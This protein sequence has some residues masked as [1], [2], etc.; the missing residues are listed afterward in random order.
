MHGDSIVFSIFLIF[1]GAAIFATIALFLRQA[2]LVA[3]LILGALCGPWGF[4]LVTDPKVIQDIAQIGIIFLLFLL[5]LNLS[6]LKLFQ[7]LKET[8]HIT[9]FCTLVFGGV[10]GAIAWLFDL[11]L[12]DVIVIGICASFS[13]TIIGLKLLPTTVLHHRHIGEVIISVLLFQDLIAIIAMLVMHGITQSAGEVS[14][15]LLDILFLFVALPGVGLTAWLGQRYI[16]MKLFSKF[17]RI[18]EYVFLITIGWC[19]G[20]AQLAHSLGLSYE[21]G[22]FTAGV[23]VASSP[24]SLY[25]AESLKPLRDFFLVMFFFGLGAGFDLVAAIDVIVPAALIGIGLLIIK[26]L[27]FRYLLVSQ[28][29]SKELAWETG[30]RLG[31]LSEFSLLIAFVALQGNLILSESFYIIQMATII[32]FMVSAYWIVARYPTPIALDEKLRRD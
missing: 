20:I 22:A 17:D 5:G 2:M 19:L 8:T 32:S 6:P 15:P 11:P 29:Q 26:P 16:L 7:L 12:S 28:A 25:I 23:A 30:V 14:H 10:A 13:S 18:Q 21:I 27:V 24:I 31:Q 3:Y 9:L 4:A 1:T